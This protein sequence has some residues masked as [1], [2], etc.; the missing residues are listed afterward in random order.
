M[1]KKIGCLIGTVLTFFAG[2]FLLDYFPEEFPFVVIFILCCS[3]A[4]G[5]IFGK[6][7]KED[8]IERF[9]LEN[10]RLNNDNV[11]LEDKVRNLEIQLAAANSKCEAVTASEAAPKKETKKKTKSKK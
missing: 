8:T 10:E 2:V 9:A 5:Y 3:F 6:A 1:S 11:L 7:I 4:F